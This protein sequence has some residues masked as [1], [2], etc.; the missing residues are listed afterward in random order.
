MVGEY[1]P[2]YNLLTKLWLVKLGDT[3]SQVD[4]NHRALCLHSLSKPLFA[5]GARP[6]QFATLPQCVSF[7]YAALYSHVLFTFC[8]A[9]DA[10]YLTTWSE[11][12]ST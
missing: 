3:P 8:N 4:P 10:G 9:L 12:T 5:L 11:L 1:N 7:Y 2:L 6:P